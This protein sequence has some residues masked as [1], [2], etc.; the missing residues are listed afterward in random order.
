MY[1]GHVA[2]ALGARGVRRDLPLWVLVLAVQACD[3]VE[4]A[5]HRL[6]PP[7][8]PDLYSH[9]FPFVMVA[10]MIAAGVVWVWKRSTGAAV[11]VLVLY[12]S[13]PFADYFTAHKPLWL[14][15]PSVGLDLIDRPL[16][17][18]IVQ[19]ALCV[20]GA[21]LYRRSLPP[22]RRRRIA[23][24][25]PLVVLLVLQALADSR[26]EWIRGRRRRVEATDTGRTTMVLQAAMRP[27]RAPLPNAT[28]PEDR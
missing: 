24:A 20:I 4:L 10:A 25:A 7:G 18:F 21:A 28:T 14:G 27:T 19:A 17:D 11:T 23:A 1:A 15:G 8:A 13:H 12:L 26:L 5:T 16:A 6:T 2:I 22:A 3:W 9:A